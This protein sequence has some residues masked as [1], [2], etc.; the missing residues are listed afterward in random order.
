MAIKIEMVAVVIMYGN[1]IDNGW[2]WHQRSSMKEAMPLPSGVRWRMKPKDEARTLV[3][4]SVL[5]S[6]QYFDTDS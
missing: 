1:S 6:L 2:C 4:V 3:R 5:C